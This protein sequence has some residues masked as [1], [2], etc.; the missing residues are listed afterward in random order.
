MFFLMALCLPM[1]GFSETPTEQLRDFYHN[2][3]WESTSEKLIDAFE[4]FLVYSSKAI[5]N[6]SRGDRRAKLDGYSRFFALQG[7]AQPRL[8]RLIEKKFRRARWR[9]KRILLE[10][11]KRGKDGQLTANLRQWALAEEDDD[12]AILIQ[13]AAQPSLPPYSILEKTARTK[14]ELEEQWA[15]FF[16]TGNTRVVTA[17][18]ALLGN[19]VL[20]YCERKGIDGTPIRELYPRERRLREKAWAYLAERV[21]QDAPL[22]AAL[23]KEPW[24]FAPGDGQ[25]LVERIVMQALDLRQTV[26]VRELLPLIISQ[27]SNSSRRIY[28]HGAL[29]QLEKNG[30]LVKQSLNK[31]ERLDGIW[32]ERFRGYCAFVRQKQL[33]EASLRTAVPAG[34]KKVPL[35]CSQTL[36]EAKQLSLYAVW[37]FQFVA[38][39]LEKQAGVY[40]RRIV[41]MDEQQRRLCMFLKNDPEVGWFLDEGKTLRWSAV[42]Q[43]WAPVKNR[44]IRAHI[45]GMVGIEVI[46]DFLVQQIPSEIYQVQ[47]PDGEH[48]AGL[49]YRRPAETLLMDAALEMA[50]PGQRHVIREVRFFTDLQTNRVLRMQLQLDLFQQNK[51]IARGTVEK[52]FYGYADTELD[53]I[54]VR[55]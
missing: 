19:K 24:F 41:A 17:S 43:K 5:E 23:L 54:Q 4:A 42:T 7:E 22:R 28:Y 9:E 8:W 11:C 16:A 49:V 15:V 10:I 36:A 14:N 45:E 18:V 30:R 25:R 1:T 39:Q 2:H 52:V 12:K 37:D 31:L 50:F 27:P 53:W 6:S 21:N 20:G 38:D 29:A 26:T 48:Y 13:Q 55:D 40:V 32:A 46:R 34:G 3:A 33:E 47:G 44:L 35:M 51:K